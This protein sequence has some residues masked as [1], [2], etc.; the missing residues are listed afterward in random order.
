VLNR[1]VCAA[2]LLLT[3]S[4]SAKAESVLFDGTSLNDWTQGSYPWGVAGGYAYNGQGNDLDWIMY[5]QTFPGTGAYSITVNLDVTSCSNADPRPRIHLNGD[6]FY[7]GNEGFE[8]QYEIYGSYLSDVKQVGNDA[9]ALNEWTTLQLDVDAN[10]N[11]S[12]YNDGVLTHTAV[13]N[14]RAPIQI[15][16]N[17]GDN[18]SNDKIL[19]SSVTYTASPLLVPLPAA[20]WSGLSILGL[21]GC[22]SL[23]R[24]RATA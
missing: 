14:T 13:L 2:A 5:N 21:V 3:V 12:L 23:R 10:G 11:V 8:F 6:N 20:V 7:F 19:L 9:Y 15:A 16:I 4:A 17:P 1:F 18:W 22:L 24:G